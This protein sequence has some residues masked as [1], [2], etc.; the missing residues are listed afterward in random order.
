MGMGESELS[1]IDQDYAE[2]P[3]RSGKA[4]R[5]VQVLRQGEELFPE[6]TTGLQIPALLMK[7]RQ[8]PQRREVL[9]AVPRLVTQLPGTGVGASNFG[10]RHASG[11]PQCRAQ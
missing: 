3:M 9:Q 4:L 1:E 5:V 11:D 10:G 6:R 2:L 7:V 8:A